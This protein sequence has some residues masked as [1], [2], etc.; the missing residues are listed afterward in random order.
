MKQPTVIAPSI[1]SADFAR[2]GQDVEDVLAAG[3]PAGAVTGLE[4]AYA[5]LGLTNKATDAEVKRAYRK[6][7]SQYHPDKLVSHGLPEEMMEV[8]KTRVR[9]INRAYDRI[10]QARGFK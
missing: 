6:L 3:G 5:H 10:K 2:L 9:E 8:A 1:L 7:V 4:Q